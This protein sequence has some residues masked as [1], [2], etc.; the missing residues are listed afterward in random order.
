MVNKK[1]TLSKKLVNSLV[2][3][4][5]KYFAGLLLLYEANRW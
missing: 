5:G 4:L 1:S 3:F 2:A